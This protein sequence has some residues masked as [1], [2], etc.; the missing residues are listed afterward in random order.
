MPHRKSDANYSIGGETV[1]EI[2]RGVS[3]PNTGLNDFCNLFAVSEQAPSPCTFTSPET[4][5]VEIGSISST[6]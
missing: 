2:I 6:Q 1:D 4:R 5:V 3:R